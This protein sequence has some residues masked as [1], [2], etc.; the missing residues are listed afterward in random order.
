LEARES[1]VA[2]HERCLKTHDIVESILS[3]PERAGE[4][5]WIDAAQL[6]SEVAARI[7]DYSDDTDVEFTGL[8]EPVRVWADPIGLHEVFANLVSNAARYCDKRPVRI[9]VEYVPVASEHVF[10]VADNGP[11]IPHELQ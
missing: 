11:G 5:A 8:N 2:A 9:R 4:P 7:N 10:C 6:V 3:Q 1:L